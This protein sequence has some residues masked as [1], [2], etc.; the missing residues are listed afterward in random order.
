VRTP[1]KSSSS[2]HLP[3][4]PSLLN[5]TPS[6][7]LE[8]RP[9][10]RQSPKSVLGS[11]SSP[12]SPT[13][14]T[15]QSGSRTTSLILR[16]SSL[17]RRLPQASDKPRST[18]SF[19]T[20]THSGARRASTPIPT[21]TTTVPEPSGTSG[22]QRSRSM[23]FGSCSGTRRSSMGGSGSGSCGGDGVRRSRSRLG[24]SSSLSGSTCVFARGGGPGKEKARQGWRI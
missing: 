6:P 20:R 18:T 5:S 3:S 1:P 10:S 15:S 14:T 24:S 21:T 12:R 2:T 13:P 16:S 22:V 23:D 7:R 8:P 9:K 4:S 11:G 17:P 19:C